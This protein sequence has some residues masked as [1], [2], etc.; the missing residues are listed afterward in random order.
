MAYGVGNYTGSHAAEQTY[1]DLYRA[2]YEDWKNRFEPYQQVL[3][4][5]A[6]STE[7][8]DEQLSRISATT[9]RTKM[10]ASQTAEMN[11]NRLGLQQ[12][13]TQKA[14]SDNRMGISA[15]L[16]DINAKNSARE[17][18]YENYQSVMTGGA[19]ENFD[20]GNMQTGGGGTT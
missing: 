19:F 16:G 15:A 12:S 14:A 13:A 18:A 6:T 5:A 3:M 11:R 9:E 10:Q 8:L 17:A 2:M 4:D 1:T 20:P 7:M